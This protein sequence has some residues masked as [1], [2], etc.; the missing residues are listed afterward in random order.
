MLEGFNLI[1]DPVGIEPTL[2]PVKSDVLPL[3]DGPLI[4]N[5]L[6]QK[7]SSFKDSCC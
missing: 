4:I 6:K 2:S 1:V 7:E 5:L 3:Y